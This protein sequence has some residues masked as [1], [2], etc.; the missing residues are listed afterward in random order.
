MFYAVG[1]FYMDFPQVSDE[2]VMELLQHT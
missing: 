1:Q 2:Q